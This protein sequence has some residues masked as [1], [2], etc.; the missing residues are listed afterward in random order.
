MSLQLFLGG[1]LSALLLAGGGSAVAAGAWR[2]RRDAVAA[3]LKLLPAVPSPAAPAAAVEDAASL[4]KH[5]SGRTDPA[6]LR[7]LVRA[8]RRWKIPPRHAAKAFSALRIGLAAAAGGLALLALRLA[9]ADAPP[10][11]QLTGAIGPALGAWLAPAFLLRGAAKRHSE[12]VA[13]GLPEALELLLVCVEAGLSLEDGIDRI[14]RELKWSQPA[15]SEELVQTSADLKILPDRDQALGNLAARI[16]LPSVRSVVTSLSQ[17]LRYGT[18][19]SQALRVTA[20]ELR[21]DSLVSLEERANRLPTLLTVPMMLFMMPTIFLII[22]G[23]AAIRM[24]D[25]FAK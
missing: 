25:A 9:A 8:C 12:A 4:L 15:L 20:A 10:L 7:V 14:A 6:E 1:A 16:D 22:G 3:R 2:M 17:T 23:P 21:N 5:A 13:A 11:L 24:L 18:P 19:L